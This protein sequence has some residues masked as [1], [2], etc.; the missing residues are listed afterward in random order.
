MFIKKIKETELKINNGKLLK[1]NNEL[2][3]ITL[4][5]QWNSSNGKN[6][7][8]KYKNVSGCHGF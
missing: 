7:N 1:W 3:S 6:L 5:F 2:V 8:F 4:K